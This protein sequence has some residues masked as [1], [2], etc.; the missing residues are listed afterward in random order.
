MG[1][2][3]VLAS[4][5]VLA[6]LAV[7]AF[8]SLPAR[9]VGAVLAVDGIGG[10]FIH[11]TGGASARYLAEIGIGLAVWM[12]GHWLYAAKYK[13]WRSTLGRAPW[14]LPV[15]ALLTPIPSR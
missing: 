3:L 14:R 11:G 10:F 13:M 7:W 4:G 6:V 2:P 9:L 15:L 5:L 12:A 8:G 1:G